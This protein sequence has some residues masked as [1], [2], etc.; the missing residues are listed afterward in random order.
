[1]IAS[2]AAEQCELPDS[3]V[4]KVPLGEQEVPQL[5]EL[6]TGLADDPERRAALETEVR[7]FVNEECHWKVVAKQYFEYL[8]AFPRPRV[9]RRKLISLRVG[10]QARKQTE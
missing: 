1:V 10:M 5:A 4:A 2:D 3:C 8:D 6:I 7:S 9:S